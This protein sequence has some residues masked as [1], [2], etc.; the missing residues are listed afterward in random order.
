M[1]PASQAIDPSRHLRADAVAAPLARHTVGVTSLDTDADVAQRVRAEFHEM[2]DLALTLAEAARF[3][4]VDRSRCGR[5][6]D[7]LVGDGVL[8]TDGRIFVRAG[9]G[10]QH[11]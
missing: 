1:R 10:R 8:S 11:V 3:F 6:L 9:T 2:P 7:T 4:A 5:I